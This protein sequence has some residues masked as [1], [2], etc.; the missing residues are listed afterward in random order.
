MPVT[1]VATLPLLPH[2]DITD[3]TF[4]AKLRQTQQVMATTPSAHAAQGEHRRGRRRFVYYQGIEDPRVLYLLGDWSSPAEH[5]DVFLPSPANQALLALVT[6]D[7]DMSR[8]EMHH[9][10]VPAAH[11]P[12]DAEVLSIARLRVRGEDKGAFEARFDEC[13][14]WL[15]RYVSWGRKPAGGWRIE[16]APSSSG[17]EGEE[18]EEEWVLLCGW[19]SVEEHQ[20]FADAEGFAKFDRIREFLQGFETKHGKRID[21]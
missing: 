20:K 10:D 3:E 8:I 18:D 14:G 7:V 5:R 15:D 2:V 21:L 12:S 1:E 9:V 19:V 4:L 17:K 11:V 6:P 13:R 16:K